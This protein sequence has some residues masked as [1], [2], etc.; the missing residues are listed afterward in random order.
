VRILVSGR[1]AGVPGQG[2]ASWAVL[3]Y[4]LGLRR[5]G[6]EVRFVEPVSEPAR[7]GRYFARLARAFG[8]D[9]HLLHPLLPRPDLAADLLLNISGLLADEDALD[10]IPVRAFVDLD[11]AFTQLW[12]LQGVDL[13]LHRHNRLV[14]IGRD[15]PDCGRTWMETRQP[16]VLDYWPVADELLRDAATSVGH[17]RSYGSIEHGGIHYGQRAHSVRGLLDLTSRTDK[18]LALALGIH[19]DERGDLEAL[20]RHGWRLLDPAAVAATPWDYQAF[21]QGSWAELGIAKHGYVVSRCGWFSDRSLCYLA[22]G[23]P[24]IAQDT[25]FSDWLPTG[26]GLLAF[27]TAEEAATAIEAVRGDYGRHRRAAR[28]LAE[29]VFDSDRVLTELLACL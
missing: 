18:Q 9:A 8:L 14:T 10:A 16:I 27:D 5:L 13:G 25:G 1:L 17:W 7:C 21:V 15:V 23:R 29:D 22:S 26:E 12:A 20:R 28:A 2:G 4:L 11:P 6:H 19:P 3:Q 24:V